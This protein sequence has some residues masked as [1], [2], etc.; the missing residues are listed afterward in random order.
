MTDKT[1][2]VRPPEEY[3]F[4][5]MHYLRKTTGNAS[6]LERFAWH[7]DVWS[8]DGC[9]W[10]TFTPEEMAE[11]GWVYVDALCTVK[12]YQTLLAN[13]ANAKVAA[14]KAARAAAVNKAFDSVRE[15]HE[16]R[17][18]EK[19]LCIP[20][21]K[22]RVKFSLHYLSRP[23]G[24]VCAFT[25]ITETWMEVNGGGFQFS[26]TLLTDAQYTYL[27]PVPT[28]EEIQQMKKRIE[29]LESISNIILNEI[30]KL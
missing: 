4:I 25:W 23:D 14:E 1:T 16:Q 21:E 5:E 19:A 9:A 2:G 7:G 24:S 20:A 12:E 29:T 15:A 10:M 28:Y 3:A 8:F 6:T 22:D 18:A 26:P 17:K 30:G 13:R 11:L 27:C